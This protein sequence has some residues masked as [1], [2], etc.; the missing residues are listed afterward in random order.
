MATTR[1]RERDDGAA[2]TSSS[3]T[4]GGRLR[5]RAAVVKAARAKRDAEDAPRSEAGPGATMAGRSLWTFGPD[6]RARRAVFRVM[7]SQTM[8]YA[9]LG[10]IATHFVTLV[11][12]AS[13]GEST[14]RG[15]TLRELAKSPLRAMDAVVLCLYT[16]EA[17]A[18]IF[19]LGF[20]GHK[21]AYAASVYNQVDFLIIVVSWL[22]MAM[23]R[24][25]IDSILARVRIGQLRLFRGVHA[26]KQFKLATSVVFI[27]ESLQKSIS[28]LRDVAAV[29]V[30]CA[31]FYALMGM[32]VFGGSLRRRCVE[33]TSAATASDFYTAVS[34]PP[35]FCGDVRNH[36]DD[37]G[38]V[39]PG[40]YDSN[41][42]LFCSDLV[43]NPKH[44]YQS[45]DSFGSTLLVMF[46]TI[47]IESW[48]EV[49]F[50]IVNAEY[51]ASA[52]YFVTLIIVGTYFIVSVF[53]AAVSG[54]FLRLRR[55]HQ[56]M[57]R[58][59]SKGKGK[60]DDDDGDDDAGDDFESN[61]T[62][63]RLIRRLN[64]GEGES[65]HSVAE[66]AM[67]AEEM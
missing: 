62:I 45:F 55:E 23:R 13:S 58:S 33:T 65:V 6:N 50:P 16:A 43:G 19:A 47:A 8:E 51:K 38:F 20:I 36:V 5:F 48:Q 24:R 14:T 18:R 21:H 30:V 9:V 35:L 52:A 63:R 26:L 1:A 44:G 64:G 42:S 61:A 40:V 29:T 66:A 22:S 41:S 7:H 2:G 49:M 67:T 12:L 10:V 28:L 3:V 17:A 53:V 34:D 27:A 56:M 25:G 15:E 31:V 11:L 4:R 60:D 59:R 54:V 57:L 32:G 46:Q 37:K 39:C